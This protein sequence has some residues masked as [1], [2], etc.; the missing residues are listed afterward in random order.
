M[1]EEIVKYDER[2]FRAKFQG[3]IIQNKLQVTILVS[4]HLYSATSFPKYQ[5]YPS[6]ITLFGPALVSDRDHF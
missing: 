5:K 6:Q 4:D 1:H 3:V 2:A